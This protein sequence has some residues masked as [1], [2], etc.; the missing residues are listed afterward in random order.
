M[1]SLI[2]NIL[3]ATALASIANI[4][5]KSTNSTPTTSTSHEDADTS[6]F[7]APPLAGEAPRVEMIRDDEGD[8]SLDARD[9]N[10][11]TEIEAPAAFDFRE[12]DLG[13]RKPVETPRRIDA[14]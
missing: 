9:T 7:A 13:V 3:A 8:G 11:R 2:S 14:P 12:T 1:K 10:E 5:S 6:A 4:D